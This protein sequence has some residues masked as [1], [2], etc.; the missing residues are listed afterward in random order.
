MKALL[1]SIPIE[2]GPHASRDDARTQATVAQKEMKKNETVVPVKVPDKLIS[3]T[4]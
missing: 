2:R 4:F 3:N 1:V